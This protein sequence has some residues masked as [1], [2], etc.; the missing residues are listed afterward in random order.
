M[1]AAFSAGEVIRVGELEIH[2]ADGLVLA[3]GR[4]LPMSV[5]ELALLVAMTRSAGNVVRREELY[6]RAWGGT[7]RPGDRTIDVY[8]HKL[9]TKLDDALPHW[10]HI[11]THV[12]FGYRF[13]PEPSHAF[14]NLATGR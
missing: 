14:H 7:L 3:G 10:R 5:R 2:P 6:A 13:A 1:E 4:A 11:H 12:G 9:R 8:V